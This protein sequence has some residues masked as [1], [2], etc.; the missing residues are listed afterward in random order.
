M[1]DLSRFEAHWLALI[2]DLRGQGDIPLT[3]AQRGL[4]HR[5]FLKALDQVWEAGVSQR[6]RRIRP[7]AARSRGNSA[8]RHRRSGAKLGKLFENI[9]HRSPG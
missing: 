6:P 9:S 4:L 8:I 3:E 2:S 1:E 5:E 7:A